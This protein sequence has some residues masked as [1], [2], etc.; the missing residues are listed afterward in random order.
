MA[1]DYSPS[2][3]LPPSEEMTLK[4]MCMIAAD[5]ND[6][7]YERFYTQLPIRELYERL[8]IKRAV[9]YQEPPETND[10]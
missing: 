2:E 6:T 9:N 8:A 10:D 1:S 4:V 7:A 5:N 3:G